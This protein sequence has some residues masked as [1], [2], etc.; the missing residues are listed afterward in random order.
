M[1]KTI[2]MK[3]AKRMTAV[4][5]AVFLV[6]GFL[7]TASTPVEAN[8]AAEW[9]FV[10]IPDLPDGAVARKLWADSP[11][12]VYVW[13]EDGDP[14]GIYLYHWDGA[15]WAEELSL[16]GYR[17][18]LIHGNSAD[19]I[20]VSASCPSTDCIGFEKPRMFR[21]DGIT[22]AELTLPSGVGNMVRGLSGA[23]GEMQIAVNGT[24]SNNPNFI[25]EYDYGSDTWQQISTTSLLAY[26]KAM[27][28]L[29]VDEGYY[30]ACWGHARWDGADWDAKKEFDFC[31]ISDLWG[32]RDDSGQL[33]LYTVGKNN[34][35][36]GVRVWKYTENLNPDLLGTFGSKCGFVFGD[37]IN[38]SFICGGVYH[39]GGAAGVWGSAW[40]DVY[41][42]GYLGSDFDTRGRVYHY[43][44]VS[45]QRLTAFG[46]IPYAMSV[47]GSGP[48]NVWISLQDG[49]L[50]HYGLVNQAP[51][52]GAGGTYISDEGATL[53]LDG[54]AS[55]DA[56][57]N[58]AL[59]EWDLDNDG[60]Y[61]DATG[62][63]ADFSFADDGVYPVGLKVTDDYGAFDVD[64]AEVT[65]LNVAPTIEMVT[66]P[67]EPVQT[68]IMVEVSALIADVGVLDTHTALWS[69]GD[70]S[71]S[72][73]V[74][75]GY[76]VTGSH[77]YNVPGLYSVILYVEDDDGGFAE[78]LAQYLVVYDPKVGFVT[79]GGWIWSPEGAL[80]LEPAWSGKVT[81]GFVSK[82]VKGNIPPVGNTEI[83][84]Q[85]ETMQ[86]ASTSYDWLVVN[87]NQA[88]F[89]GRGM[90]DEV[91]GYGFLIAVTDELPKGN[92]G[93][94]KIRIKIWELV[95]GDLIYD[96]QFGAAIDSAPTVLLEGGTIVI[97][98]AK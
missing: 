39:I 93:A 56:D 23:P 84:L 68:S 43:D 76:D 73:G 44:G 27:Y 66:I 6:L 95:T 82:Y 9:S 29:S 14:R 80:A 75:S 50:L 83:R 57:D 69:W 85:T 72:A 36:N 64:T 30:T 98:K 92:N 71:T 11:E 77:T 19:D 61:D 60:L 34:F 20:F 35:G 88:I 47:G 89:T 18:G 51:V 45:W 91:P 70:G 8:G 10:S 3:F 25:F 49:R 28:F 31:D 59:Y 54:S 94:D 16:P 12:N 79:G 52:A 15:V 87:E 7:G 46:D 42:V 5:I 24:P 62:M 40:D 67:V 32:T 17:S 97:H 58:I 74:V 55:T 63:T 26:V 78:E 22:W 86:F 21:F 33:H 96:S 81:F 48:D 1:N 38:G 4:M 37:P 41:V 90:L 65:V 53:T 13:I 2:K